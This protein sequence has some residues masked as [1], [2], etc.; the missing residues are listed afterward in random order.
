[1]VVF[2]NAKEDYIYLT[3]KPKRIPPNAKIYKVVKTMLNGIVN[4]KRIYR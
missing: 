4:K 1:M 2:S 3:K